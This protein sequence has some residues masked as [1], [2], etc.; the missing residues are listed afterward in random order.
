MDQAMIDNIFTYHTPKSNQRERYE[1]LR[2][3]ARDLARVINQNCPLSRE[4][5]TAITKLQECIMWANASI[6]INE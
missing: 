5:S 2:L 6:A 3:Y 4:K 1:E